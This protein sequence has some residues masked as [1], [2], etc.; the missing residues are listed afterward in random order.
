MFEDAAASGDG[1]SDSLRSKA[2]ST[3]LASVAV[4]LFL[5]VSASRAQ[6]AAKSAV[7]IFPTSV[8]SFSRSAADSSGS[9]VTVSPLRPPRASAFPGVRD[10][11]RG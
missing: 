7:A 8:S 3:R 1:S 2:F 6:A 11:I 4:R 9:S 10:G 5:A